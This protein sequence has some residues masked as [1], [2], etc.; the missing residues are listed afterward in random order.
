MLWTDVLQTSIMLISLAVVSIKGVVDAGGI[1]TVW[2][3]AKD[4]NRIEF[5]NFDTD[6]R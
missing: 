1:G 6:P 4:G 2:K 3:T 5:F